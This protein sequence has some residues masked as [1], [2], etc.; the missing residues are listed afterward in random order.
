M[1]GQV[2]CSYF[3]FMWTTVKSTHSTLSKIKYECLRELEQHH[4]QVHSPNTLKKVTP[5]LTCI[6]RF[7]KFLLRSLCRPWTNNTH[8]VTVGTGSEE[9][10]Q[11]WELYLFPYNLI[12]SPYQ[13][14]P[15]HFHSC[16][17]VGKPLWTWNLEHTEQIQ[18]PKTLDRRSTWN[19]I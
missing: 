3:C 16:Q 1:K 15:L 6:N 13:M 9:L 10:D 14:S 17:T 18:M 4:S 19:E 7:W 11:H 5:L 12:F 8:S 2:R